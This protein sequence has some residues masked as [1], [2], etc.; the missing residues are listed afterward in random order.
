[1]ARPA[2]AGG[3]PERGMKE[4]CV[5]ERSMSDRFSRLFRAT[6]TTALPRFD[7]SFARGAISE[8]VANRILTMVKSGDLKSGDRLPTEGQMTLALGISR[9]PLREAL[10]ALTLMGVLESRQGGRYT[11]TDL[12]PLR[13]VGPFNVMLSSKSYDA[14]QHFEA[15]SIVELD[16]VRLCAERAGVDCRTTLSRMAAEGHALEGNAEAFYHLD[17]RFHGAIYAGAGNVFLETVAL[18]LYTIGLDIRRGT[19]HLPCLV[20][21]SCD[22]HSRIA[23]AIARG[24]PC[25]AVEA[26]RG[27]LLNIRDTTI[28]VLSAVPETIL[29]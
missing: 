18:G 16:C 20:E 25:A 12:T 24:D 2:Y 17:R 8:E 10:K 23:E 9:P 7:A 11:V 22:D 28:R 21:R 26:Y 13:L 15:R 4:T 3:G 19:T 27:H 5:D 29:T 14:A 6:S 1:M